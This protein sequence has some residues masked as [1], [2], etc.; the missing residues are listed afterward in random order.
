[1]DLSTYAG[2]A[3]RRAGWIG[4]VAGILAG[5]LWSLQPIVPA[6]HEVVSHGC[7]V[8]ATTGT[9]GSMHFCAEADLDTSGVE[10]VRAA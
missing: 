1:M 3:L 9:P 6:I 10:D 5:A 8:V 4:G 7:N 2:V